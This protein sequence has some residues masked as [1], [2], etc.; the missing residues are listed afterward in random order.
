MQT[1]E[2]DVSF[3]SCACVLQYLMV[4]DIQGANFFRGHLPAMLT[5]QSSHG[6]HPQW[7]TNLL[8]LGETH[9]KQK[10]LRLTN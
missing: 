1:Y 9:P 5:L 4:V 10:Q 8:L 2:N 7:R 6:P 3:L